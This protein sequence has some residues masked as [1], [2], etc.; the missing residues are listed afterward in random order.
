[1]MAAVTA[2][3]AGAKVALVEKNER[4]GRKLG[5]TGKGRCNITNVA[6]L[7]EYVASYPANGKFMRGP[8]AAFSPEETMG[9]FQK[10]GVELKV[11]RG[12][13]VFPASERAAEIVNVMRD[14]LKTNNVRV[15]RPE[16]VQKV[17]APTPG[18]NGS[19]CIIT[20]S[21]HKFYARRVI[22][23]SGGLSYPAT[24]CTGDGYRF[25]EEL[26]HQVVKPRGALV[27]LVTDCDVKNLAGI[28]L[29]NVAVRLKIDKKIS[30]EEF[31]DLLFTHQGVSGPIVLTTCSMMSMLLA[32]PFKRAELSIDLKPA[33]SRQQLID[34]I[35]REIAEHPGMHYQSLLGLLM[36]KALAVF[37]ADLWQLPV[38]KKIRQMQV[39]EI[40]ALVDLLKGFTLP[41]KG[42]ASIEEAIVTAG[43]VNVREIDPH[44]MES[45]LTKGLFFAGEV[46]DVDGLTGGFNLQMC[47]A[48]GFLAGRAAAY[49]ESIESN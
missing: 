37:C 1:M 17:E 26:G 8:L 34:R 42:T 32:L 10:R 4:L 44:S 35:G 5:I 33:L 9:W 3:E 15:L 46:I 6:G 40:G 36:P 31:G 48:T 39:G 18:G 28:T 19:F 43:G 7:E 20:R 14:A 23:A 13:R 47:F 49:K 45:K 41:V 25:A 21:G 12:G 24:G 27:A 22:V 11:E 30:S 2:A 29:K 38:G 16:I